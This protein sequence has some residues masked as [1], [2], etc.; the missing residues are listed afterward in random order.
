[1][2]HTL[3]YPERFEP[4]GQE[5]TLIDSEHR[6][7]YWWAAKIAAGRDVL[8]AGCGAGYGIDIL[9]SSGATSV[10]G[11]DVDS[12]AVEEAESRNAERPEA[13]A[14]QGD[15]RELD[16]ADSS[17][18]L[19]VC[20]E[21]IEHIED[22][23][24]ALAE[25]RRVLRPEGLLLVSSPNPDV[26][27]TGNE[28]HVHE[29][30]PA[31]LSAAVGEHFSHLES[32]RQ[33]AWLASAIE[34]V[35]SNSVPV[36]SNGSKGA[37]REAREYRE[38]KRTVDLEDGGE[39]YSIILAGDSE[40]PSLGDI[41]VLGHTFDVE[42]WSEQ[43]HNKEKDAETAVKVA[44]N[45]AHGVKKDVRKRFKEI[46]ARADERVANANVRAEAADERVA[47]ADER[48]E[49]AQQEARETVEAGERRAEERVTAADERADARVEKVQD[50]AQRKVEK[51][52][53]EA[54]ARLASVDAETRRALA[55]AAERESSLEVR[56]RATGASLLEANQALAQVPV[57]HHRFGELQVHCQSIEAR[58]AEIE[59]SKSWRYMGALRRL[60]HAFRLK[61]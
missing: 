1:M 12:G 32:Y 15:V 19:V 20:F 21:V 9:A 33:H 2:K 17:F 49:A 34:P 39:T 52:K 41:V 14:C 4:Q 11:V 23:E 42:W 36:S 13:L 50:A 43:V 31:E 58:L 28:H 45:W 61:R 56:L 40:L 44:R 3:D 30:R 54:E 53:A 55:Q 7:R 47:A 24:R 46:E 18:D 59:S 48:A 22:A 60:R 51:V 29:Y 37:A 16:L 5:G 10:T 8:D 57:L 35:S 6:A 25:F 26:Y 27:I 38:L